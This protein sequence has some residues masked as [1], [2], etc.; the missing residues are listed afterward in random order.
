MA[1]RSIVLFLLAL[2]VVASALYLWRRPRP[3]VEVVDREKEAVLPP[4]TQPSPLP[5]PSRMA[6]PALSEVQPTLDRAFDQTLTVDQAARPAF[7]AGDFN[8]DDVP[9]LAVAVRPRNEEALPRLN[10]EL[11]NWGTQDASA[12]PTDAVTRPEPLKVAAGELLLAVV[13][14]VEDGGWRSPEARPC[15]LVKNAVGSGMRPQPLARVPDAIRMR[16]NR[17]HTGDV[18]VEERGGARGLIFWNGARYLW[19][20]LR[21]AP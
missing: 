12:P 1:F 8:G 20:P 3:Q 11:A 19:S 9:D 6:A 17:S 4:P 16:V 15:Y 7:V 21:H 14:G 5:S 10:A 13:H 18:I 2:V